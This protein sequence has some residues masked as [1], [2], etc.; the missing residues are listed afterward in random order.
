MLDRPTEVI[1]RSDALEVVLLPEVGARIHRIRAWGED[2]L[3]T[4]TDPG[5]H[6]A[7]PWF[8]GAYVMA[9]WCNRITPGPTDVLGRVVDVPANFPDGSA[10]HGQVS[11]R[12]WEN[13]GASEFRV[14]GGGEE[15]GWP[16]R[17]EVTAAAAV[18]GPTLTLRY[19]LRNL[20]DGTMPA[21][22]GLH[23]WFRGPLEL[24]V[25]GSAVYP[26]NSNSPASSEPAAGRLDLRT[27]ATPAAGLDATWVDL[28][29]PVIELA[30]PSRGMTATVT[31]SAPSVDALAIPVA[32]PEFEAV[33]VE[34]QTHGPDGLRRL[35]RGESHAL[36]ALAPGRSLE[37]ALALTVR[38]TA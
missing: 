3:R 19:V 32:T 38:R 20:G 14:E 7:D 36:A 15:T 26:V 35:L 30:W 17:Y 11:H 25:P 6:A 29:E 24:Q 28:V 5:A 4:P 22:L 31:I 1:L 2:L 27:L 34:P 18:R 33:A 12:P 37:L 21:G 13:A 10:I 23:P 9:P 16:W 8:W